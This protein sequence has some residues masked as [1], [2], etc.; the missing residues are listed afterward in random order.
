MILN[1]KMEDLTENIDAMMKPFGISK[2]LPN[3]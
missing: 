1:N 2:R 3:Q